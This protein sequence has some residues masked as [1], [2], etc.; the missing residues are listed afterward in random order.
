MGTHVRCKSLPLHYVAFSFSTRSFGNDIGSCLWSGHRFFSTHW[1]EHGAVGLSVDMNSQD[2]QFDELCRTVRC[3]LAPSEVHGVGVVAIRPVK[4]GEQLFVRP[5]SS[6]VWYTL[7]YA[8]LSKF[9]RVYPEIK[10]LILDRWPSVVNGSEFLSPNNELRLVSF[11]NHSYAPN[12]D[13]AGD[14]A[15]RDIESGE[16]VFEDYRIMPNYKLVFPWIE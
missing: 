3:K 10:Q 2:I 8:S 11:V 6:S 5:S 13:P 14:V 4:K 16:E 9:D 15:L 12:Y 1:L 7:P